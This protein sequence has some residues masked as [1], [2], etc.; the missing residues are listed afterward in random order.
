MGVDVYDGWDVKQTDKSSSL[1]AFADWKQVEN[2]FG[3]IWERMQNMEALPD[4][5]A[6]EN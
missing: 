3:L 4:N 5:N 6:E 1:D 2:V